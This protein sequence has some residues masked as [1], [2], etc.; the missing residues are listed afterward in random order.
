MQA[1]LY[2]AETVVGIQPWQDAFES[3]VVVVMTTDWQA[4]K[5]QYEGGFQIASIYDLLP[6]DDVKP[7]DSL[8]HYFF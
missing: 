5:P 2:R 7:A 3:D 1:Y 6:M 8:R 4:T